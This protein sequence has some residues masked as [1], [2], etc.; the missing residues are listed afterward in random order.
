M[1]QMLFI[2]TLSIASLLSAKNENSYV[3]NLNV[4]PTEMYGEFNFLDKLNLSEVSNEERMRIIDDLKTISNYSILKINAI[5]K[6]KNLN[7]YL[8]LFENSRILNL[9]YNPSNLNI[10]KDLTLERSIDQNGNGNIQIFNNISH[11]ISK[12]NFQNGKIIVQENYS[13]V[14]GLCQREGKETYNQCFNRETDEFCDDFIS[15]AAY[16]TNPQIALL[17]A[18]LCTC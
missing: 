5:Y 6:S 7:S 2:A 13:L 14:A 9:K 17:I 12:H 10:I 4:Q 3:R 15:T 1:K 8:V 11:D 18:A 16:I